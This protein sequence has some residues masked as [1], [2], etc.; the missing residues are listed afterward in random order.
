M[1]WLTPVIC[2]TI[3]HF[4]LTSPAATLGLN[5]KPLKQP[6]KKREQGASCL[7]HF[8]VVHYPG[9]RTAHTS[10]L[11]TA[12]FNNDIAGALYEQEKA[13]VGAGFNTHAHRRADRDL[14]DVL[15]RGE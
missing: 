1:A 9:D 3:A 2:L 14:I 5:Q 13:A 4:A 10:E 7:L 15:G 12:L 8:R 11:T 6:N